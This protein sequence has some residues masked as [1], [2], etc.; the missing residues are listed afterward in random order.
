MVDGGLHVDQEVVLEVGKSG[1]RTSR[2]DSQ[3]S[4]QTPRPYS[5]DYK[6][7]PVRKRISLDFFLPPLFEYF[8]SF[9]LLALNPGLSVVTL[10]W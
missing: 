9:L 6:F 8:C 1:P 4:R 10:P 7:Y 2:T 5:R 3:D